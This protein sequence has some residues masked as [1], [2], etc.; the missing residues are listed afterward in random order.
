MT[1]S[2]KEQGIDLV[3]F[4]PRGLYTLQNM[5]TSSPATVKFQN[6][7]FL[8]EK[9]CDAASPD[10]E[11]PGLKYTIAQIT[12]PETMLYH[13]MKDFLQSCSCASLLWPA[14]ESFPADIE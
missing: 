3:P 5:S 11:T 12:C 13:G 9:R 7:Y 1:V 4:L 6:Q 2:F 14:I 10:T 8:P